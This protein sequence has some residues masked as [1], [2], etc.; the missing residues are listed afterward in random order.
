MKHD[1]LRRLACELERSRLSAFLW[2]SIP[3]VLMLALLIL[4]QWLDLF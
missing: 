3:A 4:F 2:G 1:D